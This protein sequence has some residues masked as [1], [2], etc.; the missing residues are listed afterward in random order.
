[1][2]VKARFS[3][4]SMWPYARFE[5]VLGTAASLVAWAAV[6]LPGLH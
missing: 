3:P 6:D 1:M 4:A 5:L 2:I